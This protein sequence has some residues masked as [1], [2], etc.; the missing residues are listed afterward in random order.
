MGSGVRY[1]DASVDDAALAADVMT[2]AFPRLPTDPVMTR[3][4]WA[5]P[6]AG[7]EY[8]RWLADRGGRA[9]AYLDTVHAPWA[10]VPD[11]H[12]EVEVWL[13]RA[14][15]DA[16]LLD[17]MWTWIGEKAIAQGAGLLLAYCGED[18]PEMLDSLGRLG[19]ERVRAER[20][21][22]LSLAEHG[23]RLRREAAEARTRV[24]RE[25]I[26]T[27]TLADWRDDGAVAKLYELNER[28]VQD[29]PHTLTIVREQLEDFASRLSAPDRRRDCIWIAVDGDT[30]VAMSFLKFPPVRGCV[31]TGCTCTDP[32]YRG[33][34]MARAVKL[35]SL[36]QA[37]ELG[38]PTVYTD[39]DAENAPMLHINETLGYVARPG[40]VEHHKRVTNRDAGG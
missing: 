3:Y 16:K 29:I 25:G 19:Y 38:I 32:G 28:T 11:R 40:F 35:Q 9:I 1:R 13:D 18:E 24:E 7:Y 27:L 4:R 2:A 30:P 10:K 39:N 33:R 26:R 6:R 15:L 20:V 31:W 5:N 14:E 34:G 22:E 8:T 37:A 12:C 21:W 36:A 17:S 23:P